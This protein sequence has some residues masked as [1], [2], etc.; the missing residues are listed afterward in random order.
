M[1]LEAE[2]GRVLGNPGLLSEFQNGQGYTEE[3]L[4]R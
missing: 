1:T 2:A 3:T 4:S